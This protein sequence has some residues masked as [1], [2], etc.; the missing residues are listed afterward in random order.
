MRS[1]AAGRRQEASRSRCRVHRRATLTHRRPTAGDPCG[2][3]G[4][5]AGR[6]REALTMAASPAASLLA[7]A[8]PRP[9]DHASFHESRYKLAVMLPRPLFIG[10]EI[11]RQS[12]YGAQHPLGIPRVSAV[13]DL[14]RA[15]GWLPDEAF[16]DSPR[17][18]PDQ[19]ARF[20]DSDYIAAVIKAEARAAHLR[21]G[22]PALQYRPQRQSAVRR[23]VPSSGD[24]VRRIDPRGSIAARRRHHLL[25]GGRHA[26]RQARAGE[27]LLLFQRPGARHARL[28]RPGP[29]RP[30]RRRRRPSRRWRAGC[31]GRRSARADRLDP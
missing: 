15:L 18:T 17:A 27:R 2:R 12:R 22:Q 30:L 8:Q 7:G 21:G 6:R 23:G 9:S 24:G 14:C 11:Y 5:R 20:H 25:A 29:A 28:S 4:L 3:P 1:P 19:L 26:S 31:P 10:S 16:V 13:T